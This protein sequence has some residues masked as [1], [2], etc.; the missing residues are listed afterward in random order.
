MNGPPLYVYMYNINTGDGGKRRLPPI[1]PSVDCSF[2]MSEYHG[3]ARKRRDSNVKSSFF[4]GDAD[5]LLLL[6]IHTSDRLARLA[7]AVD[8]R[9]TVI[10]EEIGQNR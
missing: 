1:R 2:S 5:Q 10:I 9:R 3:K 7:D 6:D 4:Y 8:G